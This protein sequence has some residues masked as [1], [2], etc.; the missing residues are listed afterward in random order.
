M[1]K[2]TRAWKHKSL[3]RFTQPG[4]T[5]TKMETQFCWLQSMHFEWISWPP[6]TLIDQEI[7][8]QSLVCEKRTREMFSRKTDVQPEMR[9]ILHNEKPKLDWTVVSQHI[10]G[11]LCG[12]AVSIWEFPTWDCRDSLREVGM[13]LSAQCFGNWNVYPNYL[14]WDLAEMQTEDH[15]GRS[16]PDMVMAGLSPS[17]TSSPHWGTGPTAHPT[18]PRGQSSPSNGRPRF[19]PS[20]SQYPVC[21]GRRDAA[22]QVRL[23]LIQPSFP[24]ENKNQFKNKL[25]S[26]LNNLPQLFCEVNNPSE[27][28]SPSTSNIA[29][30]F[31]W[32]KKVS[33]NRGPQGVFRSWKAAEHGVRSSPPPCLGLRWGLTWQVQL[34]CSPAG[35]ASTLKCPSAH[36]RP[37]VPRAISWP[38]WHAPHVHPSPDGAEEILCPQWLILD[39]HHFFPQR[40]SSCYVVPAISSPPTHFFPVRKVSIFFLEIFFLV[41]LFFFFFTLSFQ[42]SF[43]L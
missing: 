33:W 11:S 18:V 40:G 16:A 7:M 26:H 20:I 42:P 3:L 35:P 10:D 43:I 30:H 28:I 31:L 34:A 9:F 6:F 22:S 23:S 41:C 37:R 21:E 12:S 32:P 39:W 4:K 36:R 1:D 15:G 14:R 13:L 24:V 19:N 5:R 2:K 38:L 29:S 17:C 27:L 25:N 8:R